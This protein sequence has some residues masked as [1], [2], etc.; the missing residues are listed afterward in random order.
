MTKKQL[1]NE[2][3]ELKNKI[4]ELQA[5]IIRLRYN[6]IC[7]IKTKEVSP[8]E[9]Y[10]PS[11]PPTTGDPLPGSPGYYTVCDKNSNE[12]LYIDASKWKFKEPII[13]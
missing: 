12:F 9:P 4:I 1:E 10:Y 7:P 6:N 3:K 8:F 11:Y 5:E 2:N 13:Q